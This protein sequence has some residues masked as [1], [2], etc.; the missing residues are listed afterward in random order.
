MRIF[1]TPVC[2]VDT[3]ALLH[4]FKDAALSLQALSLDKAVEHEFSSRAVCVF[5]PDAGVV[6]NLNHLITMAPVKMWHIRRQV[7][8]QF[9]KPPWWEAG[10]TDK[11]SRRI[12]GLESIM[13][14][15]K[16]AARSDELHFLYITAGPTNDASVLSYESS[17]MS[18]NM[19][20]FLKGLDVSRVCLHFYCTVYLLLKSVIK[21]LVI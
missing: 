19:V 13:E 6:K 8:G 21:V 10:R 9:L 5:Q 11:Y 3:F 15:W 20:G 4:V 18:T 1:S 2:Q 12:W 16:E 14:P 7:S 17:N